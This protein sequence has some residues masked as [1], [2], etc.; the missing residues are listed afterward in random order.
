MQQLKFC[1]QI[2][3]WNVFMLQWFI[4]PNE[5]MF[6]IQNEITD[7]RYRFIKYNPYLV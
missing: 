3:I 1:F 6:M 5:E 7:T 2:I 4:I